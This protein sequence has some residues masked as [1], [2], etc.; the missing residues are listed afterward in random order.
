M[1]LKFFLH[2]FFDHVL[3]VLNTSLCMSMLYRWFDNALFF[4]SS[5]LLH[6]WFV[7]DWYFV[8]CE[9]HVTMWYHEIEHTHKK[10]ITVSCSNKKASLR[11]VEQLFWQ[12]YGRLVSFSYLLIRISSKNSILSILS[13][14]D[15]KDVLACAFFRLLLELVWIFLLFAWKTF[16]FFFYDS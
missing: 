4:C 11:I 7:Y 3:S 15:E 9:S 8:C 14:I 2:F 1:I 13:Y 12:V 10:I 6:A 5:C 16:I